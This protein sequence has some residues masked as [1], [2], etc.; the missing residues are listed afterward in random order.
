MAYQKRKP[1]FRMEMSGW[2]TDNPEPGILPSGE[3]A[4][5]FSICWKFMMKGKEQLGEFYNFQ[6]YGALADK[7]L[8][9]YKQGS[10]IEVRVSY[11]HIWKT[12]TGKNKVTYV[13]GELIEKEYNP[14][15][16]DTTE[17]VGGYSDAPP[18]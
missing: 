11:P 15:T 14:Y 6:A 16:V 9:D 4:C 5:K 2:L 10:F 13:V 7:I 12:K 3:A 18:I 17:D 1:Y 8:N